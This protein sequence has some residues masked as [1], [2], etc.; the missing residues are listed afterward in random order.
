MSS[1]RVTRTAVSALAMVL[2]GTGGVAVGQTIEP[3]DPITPDVYGWS[4]GDA[5]STSYEWDRFA[6]R[7]YSDLNEP[8]FAQDPFP[9]PSGW[10]GFAAGELTGLTTLTGNQ[11]IYTIGG[12]GY[13]RFDFPTW[14]EP[15]VVGAVEREP[16]ALT[17]AEAPAGS[18][19]TTVIVQVRTV[20]FEIARGTNVVTSTIDQQLPIDQN[21]PIGENWPVP[22]FLPYEDV[23]MY[24]FD[25]PDEPFLGDFVDT[26]FVYEVPGATPQLFHVF[27]TAQHV[28]V[29]NLLIDTHVWRVPAAD[30]PNDT[31]GD[32]LVNADDLLQVLSTFGQTVSGGAADGDVTG[33]GLVNADDLLGVLSVFGVTCS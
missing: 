22:G 9:L 3:F 12:P 31:D 19:Y 17:A 27:E 10:P 1:K 23:E 6:T 29:R 7:L 18:L 28:S 11:D 32:G 25:R 26:R 30:C 2:G 14:P 13:F 5:N 15:E 20:G 24:R 4:R 8:D 21:N 16:S 33:D